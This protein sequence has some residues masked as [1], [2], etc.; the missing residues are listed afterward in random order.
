MVS[1]VAFHLC[2]I[3]APF[4]GCLGIPYL[5]A[6]APP[7]CAAEDEEAWWPMHERTDHHYE[8]CVSRNPVKWFCWDQ[9]PAE[10]W[11]KKQGELV[12][13]SGH[14]WSGSKTDVGSRF[15][16]RLIR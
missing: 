12:A 11:Q 5:F 4:V 6:L 16:S 10:L 15:L 7:R 13:A 14:V 8:A 9:L 2:P 3:E 1:P